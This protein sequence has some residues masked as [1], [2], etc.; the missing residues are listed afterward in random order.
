[1]GLE[2]TPVALKQAIDKS[3]DLGLNIGVASDERAVDQSP[4]IALGPHSF[5][6]HKAAK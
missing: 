6:L 5:F 3:A 4:I 2:L 1:M